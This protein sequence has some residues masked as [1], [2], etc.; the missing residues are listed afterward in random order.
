MIRRPPRSTLSSSSAASDVYKRQQFLGPFVY[1][2]GPQTGGKAPV[3]VPAHWSD[4]ASREPLWEPSAMRFFCAVH[5][6]LRQDVEPIEPTPARAPARRRPAS[7]YD[8]PIV[9]R[10][11]ECNAENRTYE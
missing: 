1:P 3:W 10:I 9:T 4:T 11:W 8:A 5:Q 6:L 2:P 7:G